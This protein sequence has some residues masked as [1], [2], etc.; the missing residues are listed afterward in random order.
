MTDGA[1]SGFLQPDPS[2][3]IP[4]KAQQVL[5]V[6]GI[7]TALAGGGPPHGFKPVGDRFLG[8][9]HDHTGGRRMRM[10]ALGAYIEVA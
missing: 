2:R 6:D 3:F 8:A 4:A 5:E 10:L 9:I 7:Y 1:A